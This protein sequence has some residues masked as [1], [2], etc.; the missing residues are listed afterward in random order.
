M[1]KIKAIALALACCAYPAI[2]AEPWTMADTAWELASEIGLACE[3]G[4]TLSMGA[5]NNLVVCGIDRKILGAKP[6][7]SR[8]NQYFGA[9][10]LVH[11]LISYTLPHPYRLGWQAAT[12]GFELVVHQS[13]AAVGC[14]IHF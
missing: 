2:A 8:I 11:P 12:V 14:K 5:N 1:N 10:M 7:N 6:C 4:Q 3:W 9:W 13:N